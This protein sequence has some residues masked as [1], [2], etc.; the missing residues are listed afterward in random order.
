MIGL[1]RALVNKNLHPLLRLRRYGKHRTFLLRTNRLPGKLYRLP[2][3]PETLHPWPPA[4]G[5]P[6]VGRS[7]FVIRTLTVTT[8]CVLA[9]LVGAAPL[10]A[11]PARSPSSLNDVM[12]LFTRLGCNQGACHGKGSGQNGFR[13]SLRGYAPE[14]D[15][16]W[17]TRE[18]SSRRISV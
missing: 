11:D 6:P 15:H 2:D 16:A 10:R 8:G 17:L 7:S 9:L 13:L 1:P 4:L 3:R 5:I 14:W 12:P 18:Y